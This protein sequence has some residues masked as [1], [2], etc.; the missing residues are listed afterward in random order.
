[1]TI[2]IGLYVDR[3]DWILGT[4][5]YQIQKVHQ[6]AKRFVF[7]LTSW[8]RFMESPISEVQALRG[9]DVIHWLSPHDYAKLVCLFPEIRHI[10]TINH[11]LPGDNNKPSRFRNVRILTMSK[12]SREELLARGFSQVTVVHYGV[13]DTIFKPMDREK[14]RQALG[15]DTTRPLLGFF[16][17]ESSNAQDRKGTQTLVAAAHLL[18]SSYPLA[19]LISGEGWDGLVRE[20]ESLSTQVF[21]RRVDRLEGMPVLYGA[22][23]VYV[24]TSRVE[25]GPV[26]LLE[27]MACERPVVA[28]PV[29]HVLEIIRH[30]ENGLLV[31]IDDAEATARAVEEILSDPIY[32]HHLAQAGRATVL[33]YWTW[34][35]VL[36]P[37]AKIYQEVATSGVL[38]K[39]SI[40]ETL[41]AYSRLF[42]RSLRYRMTSTQRHL[43]RE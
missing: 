25:G 17:K 29:G 16:A 6:Q 9:C 34:E 19:I 26:T 40:F 31:P 37:L 20:L 39:A 5:A 4:I 33:E 13:D 24:C 11:C 32:A 35:K 8:R 7:Q 23:D 1:M 3:E 42:A 14:C 41:G 2:R 36:E 22:L 15:I 38:R 28:T 10:C 27:A 18:A 12:L 30:R 43:I 21:R